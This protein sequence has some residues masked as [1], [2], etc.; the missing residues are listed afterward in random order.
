MSHIACLLGDHVLPAQ[1]GSV[2]GGGGN[3]GFDGG[4]GLGW[5]RLGGW[6]GITKLPPL[7]DRG[8]DHRLPLTD[9]LSK[10]G[11]RDLVAASR[12]GRVTDQRVLTGI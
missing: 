2:R 9:L 3:F 1:L 6:G 7:I 12:A 10:A 5:P 11:G 8:P 4:A